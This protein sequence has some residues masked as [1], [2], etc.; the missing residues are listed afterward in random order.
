MK[1]NNCGNSSLGG[2]LGASHCG[3]MSEEVRQGLCTRRAP[4]ESRQTN[5]GTKNE[6]NN[7]QI[8]KRSAEKMQVIAMKRREDWEAWVP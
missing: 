3:Q 2:A 8:T 1:S 4:T 7:L 6:Q 5:A